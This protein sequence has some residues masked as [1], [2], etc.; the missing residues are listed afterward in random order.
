M[1]KKV[2]EGS[3]DMFLSNSSLDNSDHIV[4]ERKNQHKKLNLNY[5]KTKKETIFDISEDSWM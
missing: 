1:N 2:P 3:P 4:E 5:E